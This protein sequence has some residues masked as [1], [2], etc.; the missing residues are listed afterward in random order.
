MVSAQYL[1]KYLKYHIL[2]N[3]GTQKHQGKTKTKFELGDLDQIFKVTMII[4]VGVFPL[5]Y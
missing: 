5:K 3:F 1:K 4:C 2:A